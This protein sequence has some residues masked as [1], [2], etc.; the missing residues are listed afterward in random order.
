M[1]GFVRCLSFQYFNFGLEVLIIMGTAYYSMKTM[2]NLK[3][4]RVRLLKTVES[5]DHFEKEL[6]AHNERGKKGDGT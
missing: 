3:K 2:D 4:L 5:I 1:V 6:N